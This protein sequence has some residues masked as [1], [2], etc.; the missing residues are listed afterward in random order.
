MAV[1]DK[2]PNAKCNAFKK[3]EGCNK[4][5]EKNCEDNASIERNFETYKCQEINKRKLRIQE[6]Y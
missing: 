3:G 2:K 4:Y 5:F 1:Q 6:K